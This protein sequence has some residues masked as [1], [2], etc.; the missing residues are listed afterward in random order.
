MYK[1]GGIDKRLEK[2]AAEMNKI[3]FKYASVFSKM[4]AEL[5]KWSPVGSLSIDKL[6]N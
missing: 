5:G 6:M 3:S 2:E 4:K 1:L